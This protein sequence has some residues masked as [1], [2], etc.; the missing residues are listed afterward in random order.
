MSIVDVV[1]GAQ[2]GSESKGL[3]AAY[4]ASQNYYDWIVSCATRNAGHTVYTADGKKLVAR[5]LPTACVTSPAE[6]F[7]SAGTCLNDETLEHEIREFEA[8]GVSIRD[9]LYI[10]VCAGL[11]SERHELAERERGMDINIGSTCEG[12]G[13][14]LVDRARRKTELF[15]ERY[16][17][18]YKFRADEA[19]N[20][21]ILLECS[22]G[23]L[24]SN[25]S[26]MYPY[27][28]SRI[29]STAAYL[30]YAKQSPR[31]LRDVYGIF[32]TWPIRVANRTDKVLDNFPEWDP[33]CS[34][35]PM[36][37]R[38]V[39]WH[40][41]RAYCGAT[42]EQLPTEITTVTKL[43][44]RISEWN[45]LLA[46][47]AIRENGINRPCLSF[48]NYI[49]WNTYG[50]R[51]YGNLTMKAKRWICQREQEMGLPFFYLSASPTVVFRR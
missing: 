46:S 51:S 41:V 1:M 10:S 14:A 9:R 11:L 44:R 7:I 21:T 32:R 25:L 49:D 47:D 22:Q 8:A 16:G 27:V 5:Y 36:G 38:E 40:T 17:H 37:H 15:A 31:D 13:E 30:S 50:G 43:P 3:F 28:T 45:S 35:G 23:Y 48:V 24:L 18:K 26:P 33:S 6:I 12:V 20:G 4:I 34:S 29:C 2:W 39:D 19:V 42:E